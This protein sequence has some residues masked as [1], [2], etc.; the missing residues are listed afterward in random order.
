MTSEF[1]L[2]TREL[3]RQ[4][5]SM[6]RL[7]CEVSSDH[8][9]GNQVIAVSAGTP[10]RLDLTLESVMEGVL[11][12]GVARTR[13]AGECVR[14]LRGLGTELDVDITELFAYPG[15]RHAGESD[16]DSEPPLELD[17][18]ELDLESTVVDALVTALPFRP[19]CDPACGGLCP[20][21]GVRLD[22]AEPSHGHERIDPRW[23]ALAALAGGAGESEAADHQP[24]A[25]EQA[26][27][28]SAETDH[29][30]G[31]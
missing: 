4:P 31:R 23:S 7:E 9:L 25:P 6:E 28:P 10:I 18:D 17:G 29:D 14:C 21:C 19:L 26:K 13:A 20:E 2:S 16:D 24:S 22:D 27:Q 15:R 3:G 5:G 12:T 30:G 1:V 8:D 11:V